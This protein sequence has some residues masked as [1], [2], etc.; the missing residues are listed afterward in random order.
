MVIIIIIVIIITCP[1]RKDIKKK[2]LFETL[3]KIHYVSYLLLFN[4]MYAHYYL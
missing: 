1:R 2:K 4:Y 3:P